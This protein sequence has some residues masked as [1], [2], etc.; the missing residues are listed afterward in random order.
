MRLCGFARDDSGLSGLGDDHHD[1]HVSGQ[2]FIVSTLHSP[3]A[4]R[5]PV[6]LSIVASDA[7]AALD[8][9]SPLESVLNSGS[10]TTPPLV[11]TPEILQRLSAGELRL[12]RNFVF[13]RHGRAFAAEDLKAL[14]G[15]L[16][17]YRPD[18][19]YSDARLGPE[20]KACVDAAAAAEARAKSGGA[21]PVSAA[22]PPAACAARGAGRLSRCNRNSRSAARR[23]FLCGRARGSQ[24]P[25]E[26]KDRIHGH[27]R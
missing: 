24:R 11:C 12:M 9:G 17:W 21:A 14:F 18:P 27:E 10:R 5:S 23:S 20:D 7:V 4:V 8:P 1:K 13:A 19:G 26:W 2:A 25:G 15:S 3:G 22:A 6:L 16:A